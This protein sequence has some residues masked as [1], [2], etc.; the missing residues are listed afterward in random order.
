MANYAP[1]VAKKIEPSN[2]K[3][4]KSFGIF[5]SIILTALLVGAAAFAYQYLV[6][7]PNQADE[8][9]QKDQELNNVNQ[10]YVL[11]QKELADLQ[12][13]KEEAAKE[14]LTYS[15]AQYGYSLSYPK[16]YTMLDKSLIAD[17]TSVHQ[18]LF[19]GQDANSVM[20]KVKT[21]EE[22][23]AYMDQEPTDI[24]GVAG[25]TASKYVFENGICDGP[26]C[27]LPVVAVKFYKN[28][29]VYIL[30]FYNVTDITDQNLEILNSFQFIN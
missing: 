3:R 15:N 18:I 25:M 24:I 19:T 2:E 7:K 16:N 1:L 20:V 12:K 10:Q 9:S 22:I 6:V 13:E 5:F 21:E 11:T 27:S 14:M 23:S 28:S 26:S 8:L 30:E 4:S 29:E 17:K